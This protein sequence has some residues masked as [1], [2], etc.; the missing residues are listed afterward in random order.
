[1]THRP[2]D[3]ELDRML[4]DLPRETASPGF[5]RR[6]LDDLDAAGRRRAGRP[7]LLAAA[8]A[9]AA[10]L[11]VGIWLVPQGDPPP[12]PAETLA[13]QEEHR[14]L[15]EELAELKAS[16]RQ[17]R[18]AAP[19]LYLGGNENVD[20]VLDLG[21]VWAGETAADV[22]PAVYQGG[23]RPRPAGAPRRGERR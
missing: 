19:V 17:G 21:P 9:A 15:V 13:L 10:A 8:A 12:V 5:S 7:W 6:V 20:L 1:M 14:R 4:A 18:A 3:R 11:V 23:E 22:R 2:T 16:L